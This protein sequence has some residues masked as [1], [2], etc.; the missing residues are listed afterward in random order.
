MAFVALA[1]GVAALLG[2]AGWALARLRFVRGARRVVGRV[3]DESVSGTGD[4]RSWTQTIAY[5]ADDGSEALFFAELAS[6]DGRPAI[7]SPVAVL[8]GG[9]A[10]TA[11]VDRPAELW[12]GP[13]TLAGLGATLLATAAILALTR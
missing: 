8:V 7:G 11:R 4:E 13:L 5:P 1:V 10:Q 12:M 2:S 6:E 3:L 9:A